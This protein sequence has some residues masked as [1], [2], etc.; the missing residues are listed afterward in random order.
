MNRN[1]IGYGIVLAGLA[2][3]VTLTGCE[4]PPQDDAEPAE[5]ETVEA[6]A[7]A[8]SKVEDNAGDEEKKPE[9]EAPDQEEPVQPTT[10][11]EQ[12][13]FADTLPEG[14][15]VEGKVVDGIAWTDAKGAN[16]VIF[17]RKLTGKTGTKL[18][19]RHWRQSEGG[20]WEQVR[21][22]VELIDECEFDT[23][24]EPLTGDWSVTD[25]DEDSVGEATFAWRSAC[26]SDVS[27]ATHKVLV[28]EDG[29]KYVLRGDSKMRLSQTE[30]IGGDYKADPAFATAP[31]G[32][33]AH[34]E[35]VWK[36]TV[37]E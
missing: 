24:L 23:T 22:F 21:Q 5:A 19:A 34:A 17:G 36:A 11:V 12:T 35:K 37:K 15:S 18:Q 10:K 27:P 13:K 14:V 25:L 1:R 31:E 29:E 30:W 2:L 33:L 3:G 4:K 9:A 8:E 28:I 26:R 7:S 32:F 16:M 6:E 20:D